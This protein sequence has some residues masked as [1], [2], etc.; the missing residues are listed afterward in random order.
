MFKRNSFIVKNA[1]TY[2]LLYLLSIGLISIFL[3]RYSSKEILSAADKKLEHSHDLIDLQFSKYLDE[4]Q[5]DIDHLTSSPLIFELLGNPDQG[6]IKFLEQDYLSLIDSKI[7]YA[8]IRFIN[9]N[10]NEV[11]RVDRT[12]KGTMVVQKSQLQNKSNRDYF[13]QAIQYKENEIYL[14]NIDLNKEFG[15]ISYPLTPTLRIASPVVYKGETKGII[16]INALLS[17]LFQDLKSTAGNNTDISIINSDG[18]YV[19]HKDST[20]AF[21]FEFDKESSY[22]NEYRVPPN[23]LAANFSEVFK[24]QDEIAL[25][26]PYS[27]IGKEYVLYILLSSESSTILGSYFKWR[28][29]SFVVIASL[30]LLF[31]VLA[32]L[33][34]RNQASAL[35]DITQKI[36][37]FKEGKSLSD[38]PTQRKDEIGELS[39]QFSKMASTVHE[40]FQLL[41]NEK[42]RAENAVKDKEE[43]IENMSHEIRNPLQSILG[44][45][46][47]LL[48]NAPQKHQIQLL[49]SLRLNTKN[50]T[51]LVSDIL[52]YKLLLRKEITIKRSWV[53]LN[54]FIEDLV[55]SHSY[56]ASLE[57]IKIEKKISPSLLN[58]EGHTDIDRLSQILNN[59]IINAIKYT[60]E[61]GSIQ[62]ALNE[63]PNNNLEFKVTDSG[64][65]I[66]NDLI[67]A[68]R[69]RYYSSSEKNTYSK[70]FGLGLTIITELL[71]CFDSQLEI[72]SVHGKG[73]TFYFTLEMDIREVQK[74]KRN[75]AAEKNELM[76][77]KIIVIDDDKEILNLIQHL[78]KDRCRDIHSFSHPGKVDW[79]HPLFI[80]APIVIADN[81]YP[82]TTLI[83][84]L[85]A[86]NGKPFKQKRLVLISGTKVNPEL[87]NDLCDRF[88]FLQKPFTKASLYKALSAISSSDNKFELD[89]GSIKKDYDYQEDK[90]FNALSILTS[91]FDVMNKALHLAILDEDLNAISEIR[92]KMV[93]T[94]RRLK[95]NAFEQNL[96]EIE[97]N[98]LLIGKAATAESIKAQ[99]DQYI[100]ELNRII[101][102]FSA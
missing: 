72:D 66:S 28:N 71:E 64:I 90:I 79:K 89:I 40:N 14:S 20:K 16:V 46:E 17:V 67:D 91:E 100:K 86:H 9:S 93:T 24:D 57:K 95:L 29:T 33:I 11:V 26:R 27:L 38:L 68:I 10:G 30:T 102:G 49:N 15:Q 36:I 74:N 51:S 82:D 47:L 31:L 58:K 32:L 19:L 60:E 81:R 56:H 6:S 3:L 59:L 87:Y 73:S 43:F 101:E 52:D 13:K 5:A 21:E 97:K 85:R 42:N 75:E 45:T 84:F 23:K 50:L 70:S 53:N 96:N 8:Q 34:L 25:I 39:R 69:Q 76:L 18:Y 83:D 55:R 77:D 4:L 2:L 44:L 92:H 98:I 94:V 12:S 54:A 37:R 1:L 22:Y 65:G 61:G 99:I 41:E 63:Q 35:T 88:Y 78:L 7:D 80:N 48:S 62:I